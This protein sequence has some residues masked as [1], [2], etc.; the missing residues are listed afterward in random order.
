MHMSDALV[1]VAV[2]TTMAAASAGV[3]G[4]SIKKIK[5]SDMEGSQIP[6]MGVM[7]AFVFAAQ[8][9]NFTIPVT[10]SSGHIGGGVLLAA[11]L[12][13]Y[14]AFITL[15]SVLII[16]ALFFADGGLLALGCNIF[17]MG[18]FACLV[19][20]P[21]IYRPI[22]K[23]GMTP[24]RIMIAS[25]ITSIVGLQMGALGVVVETTASGVTK[26]PFT[27]FLAL[28]QPIHLVIGIVEGVVTGAVLSFIYT[29]RKEI[30][31]NAIDNDQRLIVP[32]KKVLTYFILATIFVGGVLSL[33]ASTLPDGL[34]WSVRGVVATQEA[35][36]TS[37]M[38]E[39]TQDTENTSSMQDVE[40]NSSLQDTENASSMQDIQEKTS[41]FPH[42]SFKNSE[43]ELGTGIAGIIGGIITL[44]VTILFGSTIFIYK[45]IRKKKTFIDEI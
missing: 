15:A 18:F 41:I 26:L 34:E 36:N 9:I 19:A 1:S 31:V 43:N 32:M 20:F 14:S 23:K 17:N 16:Q 21:L 12:G 25:V 27:S 5:N 13:P 30:L 6:M 29:V 44:A 2:G 8:M 4:Y 40:N 11:L 24:T 45:K 39:T 35:E 38:Q 28:M 7:G 22:I 10:G 33:F 37:S 42:Y 3:I